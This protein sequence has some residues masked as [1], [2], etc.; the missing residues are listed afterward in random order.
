MLAYREKP[1]AEECKRLENQF[2]TLFATKTG[3]DD[4]DSASLP[5]PAPR[6]HH[7]LQVLQHPE[8]PL[9]HNNASD[10]GGSTAA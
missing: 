7:L 9:L 5:K 4:L 3:Y 1:T 8:L 10:T 2:D 6:K